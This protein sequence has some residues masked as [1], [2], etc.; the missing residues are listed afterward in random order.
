[1]LISCD[2]KN[3]EDFFLRPDTAINVKSPGGTCASARCS[4][5][6]SYDFPGEDTSLL[7]FYQKNNYKCKER[8]ELSSELFFKDYKGP[9]WEC[10]HIKEDGGITAAFPFSTSGNLEQMIPVHVFMSLE[11]W[12]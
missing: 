6:A 2:K 3:P 4:Y 10:D 5:Y 7:D 1:L 9:F 12:W 8:V 11:E